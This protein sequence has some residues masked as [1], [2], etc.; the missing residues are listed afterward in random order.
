M[1]SDVGD[2]GA[3]GPLVAAAIRGADRRMLGQLR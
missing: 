1:S 2:L 3:L